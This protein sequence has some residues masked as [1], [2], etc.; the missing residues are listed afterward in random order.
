MK[1]REEIVE[2][3]IDDIK[4][5]LPQVSNYSTGGVF[6]TFIE[7]VGAF[8]ERVY[9]YI[10]GI[11]PNR[12]ISTAV[13]EWLDM[14]AE[15]LSLYRYQASKTRGLVEFVKSGGELTIYKDKLL[16]SKNGL[17]F[18][19]AA[20]TLIPEDDESAFVEVEAEESGAEY[21]LAEGRLVEL[22]T[23]ISGVESVYNHSDWILEPG[24]DTESDDSLRK[25]CLA[26]WSGL[27]GANKNAYI[28]WAKSVEGVENVN[29]IPL[30]R[31]FGTVDVVC[32]GLD[33]TQPSAEILAQVQE[34]L[35][36]L[37]PIS[38]NVL[39][40]APIEV[41]L[42][43]SITV[44]VTEDTAYET[45]EEL[46]YEYFRGLDIGRDFEPSALVSAVFT[47]G[48]IKS[49][50]VHTPSSTEISE[51]HIARLGELSLRVEI[52]EEL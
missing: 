42:D 48:N 1:T 26:I 51:L 6:R 3:I 31:G 41:K 12:Y 4:D 11:L 37:K 39:A 40:K 50:T 15:E 8:L 44:A 35:D 36:E 17:Y 32:T 19:V 47:A 28:H 30:A 34:M 18:R 20:D 29:V 45:I 13:G 52:A 7:T 49:A 33:N 9:Q 16:V 5:K 24:K 38:T 46:V 23:P 43:T 14:K 22:V 27:S 21:N 2:E 25:R 10:D